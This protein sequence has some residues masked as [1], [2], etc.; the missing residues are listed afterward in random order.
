MV[1]FDEGYDIGISKAKSAMIETHEDGSQQVTG[2]NWKLTNSFN[3]VILH[4]DSLMVHL[5]PF[6]DEGWSLASSNTG[7]GVNRYLLRKE[8]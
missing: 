6:F 4:E 3:R 5:K 8:R 2:L 7:D 1:S